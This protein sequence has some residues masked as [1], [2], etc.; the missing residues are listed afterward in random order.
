M[1][2]LNEGLGR[3][4]PTHSSHIQASNKV[5]ISAV[6]GHSSKTTKMCCEMP[7]NNGT[8]CSH[9]PSVLL[10][11]A[12]SE[13]MVQY[14]T[15]L[16]EKRMGP[17]WS[18]IP[19][20]LAWAGI[21]LSP[22]TQISQQLSLS[23]Q[24]PSIKLVAIQWSKMKTTSFAHSRL[25]SNILGKDS[26]TIDS[27]K[28]KLESLSPHSTLVTCTVQIHNWRSSTLLRFSSGI[29]VQE[30]ECLHQWSSPMHPPQISSPS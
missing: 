7:G 11:R 2:Q 10:Q 8:L 26:L 16:L 5:K 19:S 12:A 20:S 28:Q 22:W 27:P 6:S 23:L 1:L 29:Q 24:W 15:S 3:M 25:K 30:D 9:R 4:C 17:S 14:S 18:F 21:Q 13:W